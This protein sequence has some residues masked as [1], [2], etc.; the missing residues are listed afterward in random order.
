MT[1]LEIAIHLN[2][3]N[4]NDEVRRLQEEVK[5][6]TLEKTKAEDENTTLKSERKSL[7]TEIRRKDEAM[8]MATEE[9]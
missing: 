5:K 1:L 6:V 4:R 9:F 2:K 8:L 7:Q 3:E